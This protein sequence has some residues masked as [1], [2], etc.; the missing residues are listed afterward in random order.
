MSNTNVHSIFFSPT[1]TTQKTI[2]AISKGTG[3]SLGQ[4]LDITVGL[5]D[6]ATQ[7][8]DDDLVIVGM[9]VYGGRLPALAVE[10]FKA[11]EGK[12]TAVVPIVVY[13]NRAYGDALLEL[14]DLCTAQGFRIVAAGAFLGEHSFSSAELPI[15][16]GRPDEQDLQSAEQFGSQISQLLGT[17]ESVQLEPPSLPGNHPYKPAMQ[18]A[19]AATDVDRQTCTHCGMCV[20]SCPAQAIS[21]TDTGPVIDADDCIWCLACLRNCPVNAHSIA[22]PKLNATA[23]RLHGACQERREPESFMKKLRSATT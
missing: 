11:I 14:S 17:C 3:R 8:T 23:Q 5:S 18:P 7:F 4:T 6:G 12:N 16:P 9:P 10:R 21:M 1:G 22:L 20:E 19:G 2:C 13:G 15:A